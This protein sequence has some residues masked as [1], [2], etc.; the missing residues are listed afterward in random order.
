MTTILHLLFAKYRPSSV[1]KIGI[2]TG[3][4]FSETETKEF[5]ALNINRNA[6]LLLTNKY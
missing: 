2:S 1:R 5:M 4:A 3:L 6:I